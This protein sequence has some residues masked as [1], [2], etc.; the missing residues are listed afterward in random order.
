MFRRDRRG[1]PSSGQRGLLRQR[2][3]DVFVAELPRGLALLADMIRGN[4]GNL[5]ISLHIKVTI[6]LKIP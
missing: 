5:T 4:R 1:G 3:A 2:E 6:G